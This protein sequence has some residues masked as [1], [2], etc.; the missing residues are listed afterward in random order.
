MIW[1][2]DEVGQF[3]PFRLIEAPS[4]VGETLQAL[5]PGPIWRSDSRN[6]LDVRLRG[7]ILTSVTVQAALAGANALALLDEA[8]EVEIVTAAQ[9]E[10][11]GIRQFRLSGLIRGLGGSEAAASRSLPAGSR[12]VV[13]DGAA[14]ALASELSE[15][16]RARRYRVGPAQ[17][18]LGDATM[19][20]LEASAS[21]DALLPLSPVRLKARRLDGG[22]SLSWIRRTRIDGDSWDLLEVPLGEEFER[23]SVT[24]LDG[25]SAVRQVE[26]RAQAWTYPE[27]LELED[28][29]SV[30]A[31]LA[32]VIAQMSATVGL[33]QEWRGRI[34]VT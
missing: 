21:P 9:V 27:S 20:E 3:E 17:R 12:V 4:I 16:G 8:G 31:E 5:P 32:L 30:Q 23:Y 34:P 13:L 2:A 33:G 14:V 6:T 18:D 7:G 11:I 15:I 1:R 24:I 19:L 25:V 29:G 28:F 22:I 26:T 10:L